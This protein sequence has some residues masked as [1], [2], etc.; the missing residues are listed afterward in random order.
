MPVG[1]TPNVLDLGMG[2]RNLLLTNALSNS[3][4]RPDLEITGI[5]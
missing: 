2:P 4:V 3:Y 1:S 5:Q